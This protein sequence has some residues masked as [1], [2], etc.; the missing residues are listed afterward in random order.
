MIKVKKGKKKPTTKNT[1]P[2][3]VLIQIRWRNQKFF[4]EA[5]AQ[6]IQHHQTSFTTNAKGTSLGRKEKATIRND[7]VTKWESSLV[8]ATIQ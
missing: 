8:N 7:K 2:S 1:L 5:K 3:K 4:R 6:R